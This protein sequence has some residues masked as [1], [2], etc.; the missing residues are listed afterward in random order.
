LKNATNICITEAPYNAVG[1]GTTDNTSAFLAAIAAL[2]TQ[3]GCGTI[4]APRGVFV[5]SGPLLDTSGAN[6]VLPMPKIPN[7][8]PNLCLI[9]IR[10]YQPATVPTAGFVLKFPHTGGGSLFGGFDS[11]TGGGFPPFTNVWLDLQDVLLLAPDNPDFTMVDATHIIDFTHKN[12]VIETATGVLATNP[13]G[14]GIKYPTLANGT[15]L[16]GEGFNAIIGFYNGLQTGEH[17][18]LSTMDMS[19]YVNGVVA[20]NGTNISTY[21]GNT[22][23]ITYIWFGPGTNQIVAGTNKSALHIDV[24]DFETGT[25]LAVKDPGSLIYGYG[26]YNVPDFSGAYSYCSIPVSGGTNFS[27]KSVWC[28]P[29]TTTAF[30]PTLNLVDDWKSQE[31]TGTTLNNTGS[32]S[33]NSATTTSVT[34]AAAT[35]FT[36]NV[37]TYNGTSSLATAASATSTNFDGSSPF[38][39]CA[40]I[41]PSS[42][43]FNAAFIADNLNVAG[44]TGWGLALFGTASG[45]AGRLL[46]MLT[47]S[48]GNGIS[49]QTTAAVI[50]TTGTLNHVCM[51]YDGSKTAA[52]T[53]IYVNGTVVSAVTVGGDTLTGS[54]ASGLPLMLGESRVGGQFFPGAIGRVPIYNKLLSASDVS[55]MFA[56]G[57]NAF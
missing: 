42:Y 7:Y 23:H 32:D 29:S 47:S 34:W 55:Q 11:A 43:A 17:L 50:P 39:A 33:T 20:D 41:N 5:V 49:V 53:L 38:S 9:S 21:R 25:G 48:S 1:N 44:T 46:A 3:P 12:L 26:T 24:A 4:W 57:P 22:A 18:N 28:P 56:L 40:W 35:G 19:G 13:A 8:D 10:G 15:H 51:T 27:L 45:T 6:A 52:G 2:N 16:V 37:A 30:V 31:N 36:G 54:T 14:W